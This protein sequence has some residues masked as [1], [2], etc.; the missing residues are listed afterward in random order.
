MKICLTE[1]QSTNTIDL[2][3]ILIAKIFL[4]NQLV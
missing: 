4:M 2:H 3:M 1:K